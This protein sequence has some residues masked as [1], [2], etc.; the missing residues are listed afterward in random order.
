[1]AEIIW[2]EPALRQLED[3]VDYIALENTIAAEKL[4]NRIFETVS[5]LEDLPLSGHKPIELAESNYLD[6]T[7]SPCRIFYKLINKKPHILFVMRQEQELRRFL[8]KNS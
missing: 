3:I 8:L 7:A 6:I 1:M 5:R 2:T 4:V